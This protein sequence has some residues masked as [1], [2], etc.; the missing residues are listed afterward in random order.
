MSNIIDYIKWR[1]DLSFSK[2][3]F[4]E[5]DGLIF[6]MLSYLIFDGI[7]ES[8][9]NQDI[10]LEEFAKKNKDV[11]HPVLSMFFMKLKDYE[12]L[13][14][15]SAT[16][17][18]FGQ[19]KLHNYVN[20]IDPEKELQFSAITFELITGDFVVAYRGTDDT[21]AGW[22]EDFNMG[23]METVPSQIKS[24]SYLKD[25]AANFEEGRIYVVGHSKGGN[26]ALYSSI[27][28][29]ISVNTRIEAIY[30]YDGPGFIRNLSDNPTYKRLINRI[31]TIVPQS[32]IIGMLL[33]RNEDTIVIKSNVNGGFM[34]HYGFTWE[35]TGTSFERMDSRNKESQII[36]TAI[37]QFTVSASFEQRKQLLNALTNVFKGY[38]SY[39]LTEL[40]ADKIHVINQLAKNLDG[41]DKETK[42]ALTSS[43]RL[44][45]KEGV[46]AVKYFSGFIRNN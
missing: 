13:L 37:K 45:F 12:D 32:S 15:I 22:K 16:S 18:R 31:Y 42:S 11:D 29:P 2:S 19:C 21:V 7:V 23:I 3:S 6:S 9:F 4:N 25:T 44:I 33:D 24:Y 17:N 34:Q 10:T 40:T 26:L 27:Y 39:T 30:N 1:G 41:L 46:S 28:S 38:E 14:T 35:L 20:E 36:D 5:V 43:L 8:G